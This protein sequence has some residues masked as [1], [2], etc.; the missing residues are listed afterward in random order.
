MDAIGKE[1]GIVGACTA[2]VRLDYASYAIKGWQL[3]CGP[4][5]QFDDP[6]ARKIAQADTG[7]GA[8][9][10]N[11]AGMYPKDEYVFYQA[12]AD[13]GGVGVVRRANGLSVFGGSIVWNGAGDITYPKTWRPLAD[14][15]IGCNSKTSVIGGRGFDLSSG[16]AL[17]QAD[18]DKALAA[19]WTTVLADGMWKNSYLF[20]AM[21]LMYPRSVGSFDPTTAEWIVLL[22]SGWLE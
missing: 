18:V 14:L 12:P 11:I 13:F 19:V 15:G 22:D 3:A 10:N 5:G 8:A 16:M 6:A 7:F 4:Y 9:G 2:T 1:S 21:V 17:S 20:E